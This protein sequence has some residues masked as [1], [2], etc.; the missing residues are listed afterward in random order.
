MFNLSDPLQTIVSVIAILYTI[1]T[2]EVAHGLVALWNGDPTA[3]EQGRLTFNPLPHIDPIGLISLLLF[4]FG[5]A[6]PVPI[7]PSRF[8]NRRLGLLTTSLAGVTTN[9]LSAL[10][11]AFLLYLI[12][13]EWTFLAALLTEIMLYGVFFFVFNLIPIPPLDGSKVLFSILPEE[14]E[15]QVSRYEHIT[16][17]LIPVLVFSGA[18]GRISVPISNAILEGMLTFVGGFFR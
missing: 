14:V 8:T 15:W 4:H 1:L 11:A 6:K 12:P 5:W 17:W 9:F 2:H 10:I 16:R 13:I 7:N 3:K 18:L